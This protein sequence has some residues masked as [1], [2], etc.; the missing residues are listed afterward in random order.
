MALR[1]LLRLFRKKEFNVVLKL[2]LDFALFLEQMMS[3]Q[4]MGSMVLTKDVQSIMHWDADLQ[5]GELYSR[6][7]MDFHQ[8]LPFKKQ[9]T[10]LRDTVLSAKQMV[11]YQLLNQKFLQMAPMVLKFVPKLLKKC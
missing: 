3:L 2:M 1:P 7:E 11:L 10:H 4:L 8:T 6:S 5:N 9:L